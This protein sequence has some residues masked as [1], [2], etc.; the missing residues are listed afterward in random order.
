MESLTEHAWR[1]YDE[2]TDDP[3]VVR[4]SIPILFFGDSER[5]FN[6]PIKVV[7]VGLNPSRKEFPVADRFAR[8]PKAANAIPGSPS[9]PSREEYVGALNDYFR[10]QPYR[11]WFGWFEEV[12]QGM[13][14]SYYDGREN[15][16]LH[17]DICSP[18]ATDPT[19]SN[20]GDQRVRLGSSGVVLWHRLV[21]WLEPDV[22]V[23]SIA[24]QYRDQITF[25]KPDG[26]RSFHTIPRKTE[27]KRP[28]QVLAQWV[29][30]P[31]GK[32]T[33]FVFG[34]AAQQPF[35]TLDKLARRG[36]GHEV[37]EH[38]DGR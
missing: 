27:G 20:L 37:K 35:A 32:A 22:I 19:W 1:L 8:F 11:S 34:Q 3:C 17:T 38:F 16:A 10:Q 21:Q 15:T 29:R 14:A 18:L 36:I 28:Y 30:L 7:T 4:P 12:I 25:V 24:R 23:V 2:S 33:L 5:Y 6:S 9:Q 13:G 26:W 31:G